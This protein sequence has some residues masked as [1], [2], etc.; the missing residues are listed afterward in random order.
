MKNPK[1]S[2]IMSTYNEPL[3]WITKSIDSILNQTF[4][5]FEF[6]IIDDNPK[7][8]ELQEFLKK[9]EKQD[10]RSKLIN[11]EKNIGLTKSL[12]KGLKIAKG[13]YIARMDADDIS[14]PQRLE[15]QYE[16]LEENKD[17]FLLGTSAEIINEEGKNKEIRI[18]NL[19]DKKIKN[20]LLHDKMGFFHPSIMFRNEGLTYRN[21]FYTAQDR[22][23]YFRLFTK[24]KKF[25]N[26]K[27]P[28]IRYRI[29]S[30]SISMNKKIFQVFGSKLAQKFYFE[31]KKEGLDSYNKLNF[32]NQNQI[33]SFLN[34]T[35]N[36]IKKITI[37]NEIVFALLGGNIKIARGKFREY[38]K[39]F[40][41][42]L[43][44]IVLF[45]FVKF[46]YLHGVYRKLRY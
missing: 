1:I 33:L 46:P 14:L 37:K 15:K 26:L 39:I 23:F 40:N 6:I 11:N 36:K 38:N 22:D 9:Y 32:N 10:K 42:S 16:F 20:D 21:K 35:K 2:V 31:R 45:F 24:S 18:M 8:K 27:I 25:A 4:E 13:K 43:E 29:S 5:D 41:F 7:R 30:K 12:N 34:T 28:L 44:K 19:E 17:I 3:K